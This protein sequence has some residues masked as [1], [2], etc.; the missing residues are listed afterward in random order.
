M[1]GNVITDGAK[2]ELTKLNTRKKQ[3]NEGMKV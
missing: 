1:A 3:N 2:I